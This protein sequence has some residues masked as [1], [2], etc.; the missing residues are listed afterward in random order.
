MFDKDFPLQFERQNCDFEFTL[1][2]D[3]YPTPFVA[4]KD[5]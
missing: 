1:R 4:L 3:F 5:K 2:S